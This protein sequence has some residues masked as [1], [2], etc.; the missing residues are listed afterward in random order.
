MLAD[1]IFPAPSAAYVANLFIPASA[2]LAVLSEIAVFRAF[3][4]SRMS[5]LRLSLVVVGINIFSWVIGI[6]LSS[7]P[8]LPSGLVPRPLGG[9]R[10]AI[11]PGPYWGTIAGWSFVWACFLSAFLEYGILWAFRR[12]LQFQRLGLCVLAANITSYI[13]IATTVAIYLHARSV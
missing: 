3:Q 6:L 7:L 2:V 4:G 8:I 11:T 12:R 10:S 9:G 1:V 13:V 5:L